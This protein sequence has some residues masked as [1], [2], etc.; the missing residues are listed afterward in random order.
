VS[1]RRQQRVRRVNAKRPPDVRVEIEPPATDERTD[2]IL[3]ILVGWLDE[4][5]AR[6]RN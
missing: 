4:R 5:A 6:G 3:E 1:D 2:V